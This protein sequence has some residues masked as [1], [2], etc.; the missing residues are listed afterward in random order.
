MP[1]RN[2][3]GPARLIR[4]VVQSSWSF[5]PVSS[6]TLAP[7]LCAKMGLEQTCGWF[8]VSAVH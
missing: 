8:T 4:S 5:G 2:T 1:N 7:I 6:K 3:F